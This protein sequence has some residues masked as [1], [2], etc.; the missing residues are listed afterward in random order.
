M[1]SAK[2]D[3]RWSDAAPLTIALWLFILVIFLPA[4]LALVST[5]GAGAP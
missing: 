2:A 4:I 3:A 1:P 5:A